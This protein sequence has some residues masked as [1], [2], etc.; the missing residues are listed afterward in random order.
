[1]D[2]AA[3]RAGGGLSMDEINLLPCPF[4]GGQPVFEKYE[5]DEDEYQVKCPYCFAATWIEESKEA[6]AEEW[7]RRADNERKTVD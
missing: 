6:A 4:C 1:M 7:N 3:G 5:W 2:A